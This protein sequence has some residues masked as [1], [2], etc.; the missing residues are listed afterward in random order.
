MGQLILR[1]KSSA[2]FLYDECIEDFKAR[3]HTHV[4][5]LFIPENV[6]RAL[7]LTICKI[8]STFSSKK[9]KDPY[10]N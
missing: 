9:S 1:Q 3:L 8:I 2:N 6:S 4:V 5:H 10:E 7:K